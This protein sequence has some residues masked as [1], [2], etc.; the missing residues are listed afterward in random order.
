MVEQN[1]KNKN[2]TSYMYITNFNL[3]FEYYDFYFSSHY[4]FKGYES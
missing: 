1:F 4:P 3:D 2:A